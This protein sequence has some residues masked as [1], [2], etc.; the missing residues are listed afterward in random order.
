MRVAVLTDVHGN[1]PA[2]EAAL[3]AIQADGCD[4]AV[5]TGDAIGIGPYPAECL[6]VLLGQSACRLV[7]GNH[8]EWFAFGLPSPRP[9]WMGEGELAHQR[10]VHAQIDAGL[11]SVVAGWPYKVREEIEGV[12]VAFGHDGLTDASPSFASL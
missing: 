7:M 6:D 11:R 12:R 3:R 4:F 1:L 10:W 8:D 9:T 2:L 5:H